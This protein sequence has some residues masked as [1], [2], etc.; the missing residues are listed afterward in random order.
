MR[1]DGLRH[2]IGGL[3]ALGLA[4]MWLAMSPAAAEE[5]RIEHLG[6]A[7]TG[8]LEGR[9]PA[10]SGTVVL[11]VHDAFSLH[12]ADGPRALQAALTARGRTSLAITL[13]LGIEARRKPFD[14]G[15]DHDHR[16]ADAA[17]EIMAWAQWLTERGAKALVLVGEGTGALQAAMEPTPPEPAAATD[18]PPPAK[19]PPVAGLVLVAPVPTSPEARADAYR[20]RFGADLDAVLAEA[21]RVATEGGEDTAFE[22]PGFLTCPRARVTAGAFLDAYDPERGLDLAPRLAA[23]RLPTL[24]FLAADDPRRPAFAGALASGLDFKFE[25]QILS[26]APAPAGR[27]AEPEVAAR[28][29][30]F[31]DRLDR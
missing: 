24:V 13:S 23:R 2:R 6:L 22:G 18:D 26:T 19:P 9:E 8:N 10:A 16:D 28:I 4:A 5:V 7:L 12:G 1:F 29:G 31:V 17:Q 30:A 11:I 21:R 25:T 20:R 27:L 15:F 14:C 3:A